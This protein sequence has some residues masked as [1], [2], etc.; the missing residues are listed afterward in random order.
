[1]AAAVGAAGAAWAVTQDD[2]AAT[3][4]TTTAEAAVGTYEETVAST[5]TFQP[6]ETAE[7]SFAVSGEVL[8]VD[9]AVGDVVVAGQALATVGTETLD[10]EL[11]AAEAALDAALERLDSDTDA[12]AT[13]TQLAADEASVAAAES[14]V[15]QATE[16]LDDA[17]LT[18]TIA[19]TVASVDVA[20][21][22]EVS[23][24]SASSGSTG[25]TGSAGATGATG[26][27]STTPSTG[28]GAQITVITTDAFVVETSVGSADLSRLQEGLQAELTP[29]DGGEVV[30]GTVSSVGLVASSSTSGAATF[31]VEI[32]V[33]GAVDGVYAGG[34]A[35]VSIIVE[36][37]ADVLTV[38]TAA[39]A[40]T[41]GA[42][43]VTV[44][45]EDGSQVETPVEIGTSFGIQTEIVSGL[46]AG[47][48]VVVPMAIRGGGGGGGGGE[49]GEELPPGSRFPGGEF[50]GG[51]GFPGGGAPNGGQ[52]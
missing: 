1:M 49:D 25:S 50:P 18:S 34:S 46:E 26:A 15:A 13:D 7:L 3:A 42:T 31:P 32:A 6:A 33:T 37:R 20:V 44:V 12:G 29:S 51:G 17:T 27:S 19:G 2:P 11:T 4:S 36:Q 45:S 16:A 40:T 41:D 22:D 30:Y 9:V 52:G 8:S 43:T 10:A 47:A 28:T 48:E 23:G 39:V 14:R 5:G 38:P 21:G 35:D 24:S